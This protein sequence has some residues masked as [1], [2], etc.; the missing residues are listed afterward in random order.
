MQFDD[1]SSDEDGFRHEGDT[2][3]EVESSAKHN[4]DDSESDVDLPGMD[5]GDVTA[6]IGKKPPPASIH[7]SDD[8]YDTDDRERRQQNRERAKNQASKRPIQQGIRAMVRDNTSEAEES[9]V[10]GIAGRSFAYDSSSGSERGFGTL[11]AQ[12][13]LR[14]QVLVS[15]NASDTS[16][17]PDAPS[18][19]LPDIT[20]ASLPLGVQWDRYSEFEGIPSGFIYC[21]PF[22]NKPVVLPPTKEHIILYTTYSGCLGKALISQNDGAPGELKMKWHTFNTLLPGCD[23][24]YSKGTCLITTSDPELCGFNFSFG[25]HGA[26]GGGEVWGTASPDISFAI[27]NERIVIVPVSGA[28]IY[29]YNPYGGTEIDVVIQNCFEDSTS[30]GSGTLD[31]FKWQPP[32]V[33]SISD[34]G[35]EVVTRVMMKMGRKNSGLTQT[36][37]QDLLTRLFGEGAIK[38]LAGLPDEDGQTAALQQSD[39]YSLFGVPIVRFLRSAYTTNTIWALVAQGSSLAAYE[40]IIQLI[41]KV[42]VSQDLTAISE[43]L[44]RVLC[45]N[46]S[47]VTKDELKK[48]LSTI[49]GSQDASDLLSNVKELRCLFKSGRS[50]SIKELRYSITF[51]S[52]AIVGIKFFAQMADRFAGAY[53][54]VKEI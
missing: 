31:S 20:A 6:N 28:S 53:E 24:A 33:L 34:E 9:P 36:Q 37:L 7:S 5:L 15:S 51:M 21:S 14:K 30:F 27:E 12:P 13:R 39:F 35:L 2:G 41:D 4:F 3:S 38:S 25:C 48:A 11:G 52:E 43:L 17:E 49:I 19:P 8:D 22:S 18:L 42:I 16:S 1:S 45:N 40:A 46:K 10:M 23:G 29:D 26:I 32:R 50:A 44:I 47:E 54:W